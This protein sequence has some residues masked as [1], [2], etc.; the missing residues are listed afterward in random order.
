MGSGGVGGLVE[1]VMNLSCITDVARCDEIR[2]LDAYVPIFS[3]TWDT[4]SYLIAIFSRELA[5]KAV[6][7]TCPSSK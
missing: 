3:S 7:F 5:C 2:S 6:R 4:S 1:L